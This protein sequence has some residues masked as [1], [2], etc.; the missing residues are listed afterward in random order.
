[1]NQQDQRNNIRSRLSDWYRVQCLAQKGALTAHLLPTAPPTAGLT[2]YA[3][4]WI[5][6]WPA[7]PEMYLT[8]SGDILDD[9]SA[10]VILR[11]SFST[12]KA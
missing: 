1:M 11:Q 10:I 9:C 5:I 4:I 12:A 2:N 3:L 8:T 6:H 7:L